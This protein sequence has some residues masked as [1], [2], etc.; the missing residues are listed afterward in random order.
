MPIWA[1]V[2]TDTFHTFDYK[3][4]V[5]AWPILSC[6]ALTFKYESSEHTFMSDMSDGCK[7]ASNSRRKANITTSMISRSVD[8]GQCETYL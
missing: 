3:T 7:M 5:K 6:C 4:V 1:R 2:V 8:N